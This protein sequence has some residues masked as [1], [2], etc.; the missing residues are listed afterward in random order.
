M[1]QTWEISVVNRDRIQ[2][3]LEDLRKRGWCLINTGRKGRGTRVWHLVTSTQYWS[4]DDQILS[5]DP[6]FIVPYPLMNCIQV[7]VYSG[8]TK[9]I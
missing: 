3:Q 6:L 2:I 4:N 1:R 5:H 9:K 7:L 8:K